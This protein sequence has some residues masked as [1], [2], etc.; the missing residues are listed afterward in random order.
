MAQFVLVINQASV[1]AFDK[2]MN[3]VNASAGKIK[4]IPNAVSYGASVTTTGMTGPDEKALYHGIRL[5]FNDDA[6]DKAS[7]ILKVFAQVKT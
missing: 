4:F 7:E 2:T 5:E 1:D 6:V 3:I